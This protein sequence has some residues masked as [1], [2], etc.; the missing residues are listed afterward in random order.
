[1]ENG[2]S[3]GLLEKSILSRMRISNRDSLNA[4]P[5]RPSRHRLAGT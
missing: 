5:R 2:R 4:F 3:L 1:M